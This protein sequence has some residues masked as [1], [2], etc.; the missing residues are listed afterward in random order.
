MTILYGSLGSGF[1]VLGA[2]RHVPGVGTSG[3]QIPMSLLK[4]FVHPRL[5]LAVAAAGM[6]AFQL[7]RRARFQSTTT[8]IIEAVLMNVPPREL[9]IERVVDKLV[10]KFLRLVVASRKDPRWSLL[11]VQGVDFMIAMMTTAGP[12]V[13]ILRIT[14]R[15]ENFSGPGEAILRPPCLEAFYATGTYAPDGDAARTQLAPGPACERAK[16]AIDEGIAAE[17]QLHAEPMHAGRPI[18]VAMIDKLGARMVD[19]DTRER[20][21]S[22]S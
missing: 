4:L 8:E 6:G 17:R 12:R 3:E 22:T 10:K 13:S 14:N 16:T 7:E 1:A 21:A 15:V 11:G 5:P 20:P 9:S 19:F 2:D 18:D